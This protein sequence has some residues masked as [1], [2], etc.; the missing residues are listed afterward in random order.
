[1][2]KE[3]SSDLSTIDTKFNVIIGGSAFVI[4]TFSGLNQIVGGIDRLDTFLEK[5]RKRKADE[6]KMKADEEKKRTKR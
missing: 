1:M 6:E 5:I 3:Q 4:A 2:Q